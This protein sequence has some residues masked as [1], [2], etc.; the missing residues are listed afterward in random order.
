MHG[1][2]LFDFLHGEGCILG[3]RDCR[4]LTIPETLNDYLEGRGT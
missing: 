4:I 2:G 3:L 1:H